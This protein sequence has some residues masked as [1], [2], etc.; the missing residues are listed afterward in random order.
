MS[1]ATSETARR[2]R[3]VRVWLALVV[4]L[5]AVGFLLAQ[6]LGNASI[7]F[8][9]ADE[10]MVAHEQ[11]GTDRFRL[12]GDVE[13][14][15]VKTEGDQVLF[16]VAY[17][18]AQI[19]VTHTGDPPELFR[20]GIRVVL[21]G[22]FTGPKSFSSDKILVKHSETYR[23]E[24]KDRFDNESDYRDPGTNSSVSGPDSLVSVATDSEISG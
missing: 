5:A 10:A 2:S 24:N 21:E 18:G 12:M 17:N 1:N 9:P 16:T 4:V 11:L 23:E 8:Y 7:Y 14:G 22:S 6:G 20:E 15:T 13:A 3:R 19:D